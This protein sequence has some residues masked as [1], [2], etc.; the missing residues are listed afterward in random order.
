MPVTRRWTLGSLALISIFQVAEYLTDLQATVAVADRLSWAYALGRRWDDPDLDPGLLP[1]FRSRAAVNSPGQRALAAILLKLNEQDLVAGRGR[2]LS[3]PHRTLAALRDMNSTAAFRKTSAGVPLGAR[4]GMQPQV[5]D[6]DRCPTAR[7]EQA[8]QPV[9][10]VDEHRALVLLTAR[11]RQI[12][13]LVS[14]GST[15]QQIARCLCLSPKTIESHL[16]RMFSKLGVCSRAQIA[17]LAGSPDH[18][19]KLGE[20]GR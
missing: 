13:E 10:P 8:Q 5:R 20:V 16:A 2:Q 14:A 12:A 7:P 3:A 15:N 1:D 11:E 18:S 17:A 6:R 4:E 19:R 9:V